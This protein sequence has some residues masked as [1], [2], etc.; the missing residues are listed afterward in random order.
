[1]AASPAVIEFIDSIYEGTPFNLVSLRCKDV[2]DPA[3][4]KIPLVAGWQQL[5]RGA[6]RWQTINKL[7]GS[8]V[9]LRCGRYDDFS[10]LCIDFDTKD[11][12]VLHSFFD[13]LNE[14]DDPSAA[15]F[16]LEDSPHGRHVVLLHDGEP[17]TNEKLKH[18]A[19][20]CI[21]ETRGEG[22]QV[23]VAPSHG[24]TFSP[25]DRR[26]VKLAELCGLP[27]WGHEDVVYILDRLRDP[28]NTDAPEAP[29]EPAVCASDFPAVS[30]APAP[31]ACAPA[32]PAGS[33]A[34]F[35][36]FSYLREKPQAV[37]DML[38]AA[39]WVDLQAAGNYYSLQRPGTADKSRANHSVHI[40]REGGAVTVWSSHLNTPP[41]ESVSPANFLARE[42][43]AGDMQALSRAIRMKYAPDSAPVPIIQDTP[44]PASIAG[45][46]AVAPAPIGEPAEERRAVVFDA[47]GDDVCGFIAQHSVVDVLQYAQTADGFSTSRFFNDSPLLCHALQY[48]EAHN[49][50]Q[51][52][53]LYYAALTFAGFMC[54][55][56]VRA[57]YRGKACTSSFYTLF[58]APSGAGKSDLLHFLEGLQ[59]MYQER[60]D[61]L[62]FF[63]PSDVAWSG[64]LDGNMQGVGVAAVQTKTDA[65]Q[66]AEK[67]NFI[68]CTL[69]DPA[70][71]QTSLPATGEGLVTALINCGRCLY[72]Q[73]ELQDRFTDKDDNTRRMMNKTV[74]LYGTIDRQL[75]ESATRLALK[76]TV[77]PVMN[78]AALSIFAQGVWGDELTQMFCDRAATGL[79]AR[80][81]LI[82]GDARRGRVNSSD[83]VDVGNDTPSFDFMNW[84]HCW[85]AGYFQAAVN[86]AHVVSDYTKGTGKKHYINVTPPRRTDSDESVVQFSPD[87]V[88]LV[89]RFVR[90]LDDDTLEGLA[91]LYHRALNRKSRLLTTYA[92]IFACL[93]TN[94]RA[95]IIK[96]MTV[97][98]EDVKRAAA[99]VLEEIIQ[100]RQFLSVETATTAPARLKRLQETRLDEADMEHV[101]NF[102]KRRG[103]CAKR[104]LYNART[105]L[106]APLP[107]RGRRTECWSDIIAGIEAGIYQDFRMEQ[108]KQGY[109]VAYCPQEVNE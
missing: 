13:A 16:Y 14:L 78:N 82:A 37:V 39:G 47:A 32:S 12:F 83:V 64:V 91:P 31:S 6:D 61:Q 41:G 21:V 84:F 59:S 20:K 65:E 85:V 67:E 92:L 48:C 107:P 102:I 28:E 49:V 66:D 69:G 25:C 103:V 5:R 98:A 19:G 35:D 44:A 68:N 81:S 106:D 95:D 10:V 100:L 70:Q 26:A 29:A 9:G 54:S 30:V 46:A 89:D 94:Y 38:T 45:G 76:S 73:D 56:L 99:L 52:R 75:C 36:G 2:N 3:S 34:Y 58:T 87:A 51:R 105:S 1:M 4:D 90:W 104:D 96:S 80:W 93:R 101:L 88:D 71:I 8:G 53:G 62:N 22:G 17:F 42:L 79:A 40:A 7:A 55:R 23:R 33:V 74:E 24:C 86:S 15:F 63:K 60:A 43:F 18:E 50:Q 11:R 57:W 27:V 97:T 77:R 108:V 109:R 72:V